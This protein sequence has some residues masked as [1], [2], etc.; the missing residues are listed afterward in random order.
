MELEEEDQNEKGANLFLMLF[1]FLQH[2]VLVPYLRWRYLH[3]N[4][5]TSPKRPPPRS[6]DDKWVHDA[7]QGPQS[8]RRGGIADRIGNNVGGNTAA[9]A[10]TGAAFTGVSPRIE[11]VGLHYEVTPADLKVCSLLLVHLSSNGSKRMS[12]ELMI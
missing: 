11:V 5:L 3:S 10:G 8:N 6:A 7:Y 12:I 2:P 4:Q 1:V 9:V